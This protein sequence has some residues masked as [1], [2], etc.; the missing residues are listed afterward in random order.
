MKT[1][2]FC[3]LI[4]A[5]GACTAEM[6]DD[7][8]EMADTAADSEA[9]GAPM[10]PPSLRDTEPDGR[11]R[12]DARGDFVADTGAVRYFDYFLTAE[13]EI[14]EDALHDLVHRSIRRRLPAPAAD[15]AVE[16]FERYLLYR[17]EATAIMGDHGQSV[18]T[19]RDR[20]IRL[21][22]ELVP[23]MPGLARDPIIFHRAAALHHVLSEPDLD[24]QV[25]RARVAAIEDRFA[26]ATQAPDD[27]RVRQA[28]RLPLR[29]RQAEQRLRARGG[30]DA[31]VHALRVDMVGPAAAAR[32]SHLDATRAR[33][34]QRVRAH[35]AGT[36]AGPSAVAAPDQGMQAAQA[37]RFSPAEL[38][39]LRA[40]E[41]IAAQ[42][43]AVSSPS[44]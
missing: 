13:G 22:A 1:S 31:D 5:A 3:I 16:A 25:R 41:R 24:R 34:Q 39:R 29:L 2:W 28:T 9:A 21:H 33:W 40:L 10:L 8:A 36:A 38:L 20:M 23:D 44:R 19:A 26:T 17:A 14:A 42:E 30:S 43:P 11:L 12:V 27:A 18:D 15:Q 6:A 32:L 37:P 7:T 35:R 4:L